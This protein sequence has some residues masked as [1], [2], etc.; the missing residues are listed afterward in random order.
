MP[1]VFQLLP[2]AADASEQQ[3]ALLGS[4]LPDGRRNGAK[5][6]KTD[7]LAKKNPTPCSKPVIVHEPLSDSPV[8]KCKANKT[9]P[10]HLHWNKS[11]S[12]AF[13]D[14]QRRARRRSSLCYSETAHSSDN[15][16]ETASETSNN[17]NSRCNRSGSPKR[18]KNVQSSSKLARRPDF[19]V[20]SACKDHILNSSPLAPS[21]SPPQHLS[22]TRRRSSYE[23]SHKEALV[24]SYEESLLSGRMSAPSSAPV[25]FHMKLGAL[26]SGDK[27][28]AK[29]KFPKHFS[30]CFDAVFYD[31]DLHATGTPGRGSPYVGVID[32]EECYTAKPNKKFPGYRIPRTGQIQIIISNLQKTAVKLFLVPYD[33][34]ELKPEQR[35]FIRQKVYLQDSKS[36]SKT[37]IQAV[38]FQVVCPSKGRYYLYGDLRLVFQNRASNADASSLVPSSTPSGSSTYLGISRNRD[39]LKVESVSGG[40]STFKVNPPAYPLPTATKTDESSEDEE[41]HAMTPAHIAPRAP[42]SLWQEMCIRCQ[43]P[44]SARSSGDPVEAQDP[45]LTTPALTKPLAEDGAEARVILT[46]EELTAQMLTDLKASSLDAARP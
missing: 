7:S 38:H 34:S 43:S 14:R 36:S 31:H 19:Q 29:L 6:N 8:S 37:L 12:P 35:T 18:F 23:G 26:G 45:A 39:R 10:L 46:R 17:A 28:P 15:T 11:P 40:F 41:H 33:M 9:L 2:P 5:A 16:E 20:C 30:T 3:Q 42:S 13:T 44:I 32:L 24:G 22:V 4:T 25:S 21:V 27:C 1:G